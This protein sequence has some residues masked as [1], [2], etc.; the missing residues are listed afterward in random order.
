ME[1]DADAAAVGA[2][3]VAVVDAP[4]VVHAQDGKDVVEAHA[5]FHI[6]FIA[7]RLAK[8]IGGEKEDVTTRGGIVLVAEAAPKASE[9]EHFTQAQA[10]DERQ[11]VHQD[12]V[13][14]IGKVPRDGLVVDE[15]HGLHQG[16]A[17]GLNGVREVDIGHE[18]VGIG[19]LAPHL[20]TPQDDIGVAEG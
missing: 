2:G 7:H 13:A 14:P 3:V 18:Q 8:G 12:T 17:L 16:I 19:H 20:L 10:F 4:D 5:R 1:G 6:G 11:A 9:G 15:F